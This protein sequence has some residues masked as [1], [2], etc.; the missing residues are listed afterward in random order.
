MILKRV[1]SYVYPYKCIFCGDTLQSDA[2]IEACE[3]CLSMIEFIE[4]DAPKKDFYP[5]QACDGV[6]CLCTYEGL[7]REAIL[8]FKFN[9]KDYYHRCFTK[10][11]VAKIQDYHKNN[12]FDICL[13]VPMHKERI[14]K[15]GYN[16]ARLLSNDIAL[17]LNIEEASDFF[18]RDVYTQ[19]Q[20]LQK[21][22]LRKENLKASFKVLDKEKIALKKI[23]LLDDIITTGSTVEACSKILKEAGAKSVHIAVIASARR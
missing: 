15:R 12:P 21:K 3:P 19:K 14:K 5:S 23:L 16:Q 8:R 1:F 22:E 10:L 6:F 4:G 9:E 7:V 13:S 11:L 2:S 17:L 20:S 18:V